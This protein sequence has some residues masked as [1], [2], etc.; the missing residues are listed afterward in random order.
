MRKDLKTSLSKLGKKRLNI[1]DIIK[2]YKAFNNLPIEDITYV[3]QF[4]NNYYN[5]NNFPDD[6]Y[7]SFSNYAHSNSYEELFDI[8]LNK[9]IYDLI[10][11]LKGKNESLDDIQELVTPEEYFKIPNKQIKIIIE[12]LTLL[13]D[14]NKLIPVKEANKDAIQWK[15]RRRSTSTLEEYNKIAIKMYMSIGFDNSIDLLNG[16]YGLVDYEVIHYIFNNMNVKNKDEKEKTIFNEFLFNNKKEPDNNMRLMLDGENNELFNNFDYFYNS[17]GHFIEKLGGKLN[18]AK[19]ILLLKERFIAP[20]LDSPEVSGDILDDMLSS[21]YNKYGIDETEKEIIDRNLEAYNTKLKTKTKSSIINTT[22][23]NI[24]DYSFEILPLTDVRNLVMGYRAGNC[25]RINGDAFILFNSFLTNPHMRILSISTQDYKDFGMVLLMR[26][27]NVLIAQGIE[28]SK[29]V[30]DSLGKEKLYN[31]VKDTVTH[32]MDK[33]NDNNDEIVASIIGLSNCYTTPYNHDYLPFII[34]PIFDYNRQVYNGIEN[35]QGLLSLKDGKSFSDIKL[36]VPEAKYL[37]NNDT[38]LR[39]DVNTPH[40][41]HNYREIEKILIS[42]RY[43]RFK[44]L[45]KDELI[46]YYDDLSR[47]HELYTICTLDWFITVFQD[48]SI[49]SFVKEQKEETIK[50]Y[51]FE[52]IKVKIKSFKDLI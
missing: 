2:L 7:I 3:K 10:A 1:F 51:N 8:L 38:V 33:M 16:K 37:D 46:H 13:D 15:L 39:R 29:R 12:L 35:Y 44:D 40:D 49:D 4:L 9:N 20:R 17:I 52:L 36:F 14:K 28:L 34:N 50:D 23:P 48:G 26:N 31:A 32:I 21:Y 43:A 41:S 22:L 18:R 11:F 24:G 42:L 25:F 27:G 19:V 30:P 47:K 6:F 45:P 5:I